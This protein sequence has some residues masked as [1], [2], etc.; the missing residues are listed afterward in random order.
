MSRIQC[1]MLEETG[2]SIQEL[3][4]MEKGEC[5]VQSSRYHRA[6]AQIGE[7]ASGE[8][9]PSVDWDSDPRW[10]THCGCGHAFS[11]VHVHRLRSIG[12]N[13]IYRRMDTG[14]QY[15]F[16]EVEAGAMWYCDW[17]MD[18][19]TPGPDGHIL[20]VR[21]PGGEWVIDSRANNCTRPEDAVHKC[22]VR[23]GVPPLVTVGKD[24]DTCSAGAG[25]ILCGSY[26]GFLRNGF[27]EEC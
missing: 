17:Y 23:S 25:S 4:V 8:A 15:R 20:C 26:H 12:S 18:F 16:D 3:I 11:T 27:L 21:T 19:Y 24:G 1:F 5:G 6:S 2:R 14:M 9:M 22:W 13:R 10:P 7:F